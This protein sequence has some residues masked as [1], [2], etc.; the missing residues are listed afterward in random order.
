[1]AFVD[2]YFGT[3]PQERLKP[4]ELWANTAAQVPLSLQVLLDAPLDFDA[5]GLTWAL[6]SYHPELAQAR[7]ELVRGEALSDARVADN[8]LP[9][10]LALVGWANHVIRVEG[11]N[12]PLP[13]EVYEQCV[14]PSMFEES[15]KQFAK[16]HASHV[17]MWYAGHEPDP[18]EQYVALAALAASVCRWGGLLVLNE[19]ARC[20][21]PAPVLAPEEEGEDMLRVL[22]ELPL[23]LL[24]A[25]FARF[26][27]EGQPGYWLRT[28]ANH[29]LHL[30]DLAIQV[31]D[32]ASTPWALELF[33]GLSR[34][35]R[36]S[37]VRFRP[38]DSVNVDEQQILVCREPI[39]QEYYLASE[40]EML[41]LEPAATPEASPP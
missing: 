34:F 36:E 32:I 27:V 4:G 17:L 18:L 29:T 12:T 37:G 41:V 14:G 13:D 21:V 30:P 33:T 11:I 9:E 35:Q 15:Y 5:D 26:R 10:F 28:Q 20:A 16:S 38:G 24:Y 25:G 22:R 40:G 6:R 8:P 23:P 19:A 39:A 3:V 2:R 31:A 1:M 7:V